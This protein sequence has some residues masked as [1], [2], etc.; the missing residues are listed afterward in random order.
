VVPNLANL[1]IHQLSG[2]FW[3]YHNLGS[4][5]DPSVLDGLEDRLSKLLRNEL[6]LQKSLEKDDT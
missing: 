1:S 3:I 6:L 5:F 4:L 2:L